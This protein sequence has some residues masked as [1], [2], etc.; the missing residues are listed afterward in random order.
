MVGEE[1]Y[2]VANQV[3][4]VLQRNKDLQDIISI[5][6]IE[7]LSDED[8]LTV[9]RARRIERFLSQP[10]FVGEPFTGTPGQ[11]VSARRRCAASRKSWKASMTISLRALLHEGLDRPGLCVIRPMTSPAALRGPHELIC[12]ILD[13]PTSFVSPRLASESHL[14]HSAPAKYRVI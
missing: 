7:E 6:G 3:K 10:F 13:T 8:R 14:T 1:H 11:Y 12:R 2:R 4:Q 5:L 9:E